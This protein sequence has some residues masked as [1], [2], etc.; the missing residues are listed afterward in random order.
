MDER[1]YGPA[2]Q[3]GEEVAGVPAQGKRHQDPPPATASQAS[4]RSSRLKR[5]HASLTQE[6]RGR[7]SGPGSLPRVVRWVSRRAV[8]SL[9]WL[10]ACFAWAMFAKW[11]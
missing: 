8:Q 1:S 6:N 9:R 4:C 11:E 7:R 2:R 5:A 10:A 3:P